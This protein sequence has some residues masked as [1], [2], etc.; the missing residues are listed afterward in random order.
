M[1]VIELGSCL[2]ERKD[3]MIIILQMKVDEIETDLV[4][5]QNFRVPFHQAIGEL[6]LFLLELGSPRSV[7]DLYR[8]WSTVWRNV[9]RPRTKNKVAAVKQYS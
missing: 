8:L 5:D 4:W 3:K 9:L 7:P 6:K 1:F 2:L